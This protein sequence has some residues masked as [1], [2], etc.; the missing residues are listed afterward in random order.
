MFACFFFFLMLWAKETKRLTIQST[1]RTQLPLPCLRSSSI[2]TR[3]VLCAAASFDWIDCS[4]SYVDR[5]EV[6]CAKTTICCHAC[7][8]SRTASTCSPKCSNKVKDSTQ[9]YENSSHQ[10]FFSPYYTSLEELRLTMTA[11]QQIGALLRTAHIMTF[12]QVMSLATNVKDELEVKTIFDSF[13]CPFI[14]VSDVLQ[15]LYKALNELQQY[16]VLIQGC[17]VVKR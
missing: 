7:S 6:R 3:K 16:S 15:S 12:R 4:F 1:D 8:S 17:W 13:N 11:S 14:A 5:C 9:S 10:I 2:R